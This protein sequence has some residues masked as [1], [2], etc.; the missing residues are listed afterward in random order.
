M[1][2]TCWAGPPISIASMF[3]DASSTRS[4]MPGGWFTQSPADRRITP[5]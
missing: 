2:V 4:R 3:G 1:V 5:P